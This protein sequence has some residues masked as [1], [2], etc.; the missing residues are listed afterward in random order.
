MPKAVKK[1]PPKQVLPVGKQAIDISSVPTPRLKSLMQ[2]IE[3]EL[4]KRE[5]EDRKKALARFQE[6]AAEYGL[7]LEDVLADKKKFSRRE[8]QALPAKYINPDNPK[9]TWNERGPRPKWLKQLL[10]SG[11][12]LEELTLTSV[13]E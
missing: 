11:R 10:E 13:Q 6:V 1:T 7:T 3:V 8:H 5:K 4:K 12:S 2:E 9:Q